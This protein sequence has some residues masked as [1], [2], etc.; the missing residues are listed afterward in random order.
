MGSSAGYAK[1]LSKIAKPILL[2]MS[3]AAVVYAA[4]HGRKNAAEL[5]IQFFTGPGH[6]TR[7]FALV[8]AVVNWKSLPFVWT[9]CATR[10]IF[11]MQRH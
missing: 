9:V 11:V 4:F 3:L 7:I 10:Y 1:P 6:K 5:A 2:P 8:V